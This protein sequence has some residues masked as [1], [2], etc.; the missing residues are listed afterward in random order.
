MFK[1]S[2]RNTRTRCEIC[3]KL[4]IKTLVSIYFTAY[5]SVSIVNF[6]QV[7]ADWETSA[8]TLEENKF[9]ITIIDNIVLNSLCVEIGRKSIEKSED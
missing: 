6:D 5:S 1:V 3:A 7:N 9:I 2:H 8:S 4:T